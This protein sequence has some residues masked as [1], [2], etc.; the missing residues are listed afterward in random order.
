MS[1][2]E[3]CG[4]EVTFPFGCCFCRGAFCSEHVSPENHRCQ[5][6]KYWRRK[7]KVVEGK[8]P[9]FRRHLSRILAF[10]MVLTFLSAVTV[11]MSCTSGGGELRDPTYQE[12]LQFIESD[13]TDKNPYKDQE[14]TCA[15]YATEF[16]SNALKAGYRC[17]HVRAFFDD[18]SHALNCFNTTDRGMIFV[19]PQLDEVVPLTIGQ[20]YWDRTRYA[21]RYN[22]RTYND[23]VTGFLI[24]W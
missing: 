14:Y 20:P 8:M 5:E 13:Q 9:K 11:H 24:E 10:C 12:A 17:G 1:T 23:T 2:C 16:R 3:Q 4:R 6:L 15:N 21:P 7:K 19:E 22:G 18:W